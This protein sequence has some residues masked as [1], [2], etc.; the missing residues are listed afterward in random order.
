MTLPMEKED[1]TQSF[2]YKR[3]NPLCVQSPRQST[4]V[5]SCQDSELA[6]RLGGHLLWSAGWSDGL[7]AVRAVKLLFLDITGIMY[8]VISSDL[9]ERMDPCY[10]SGWFSYKLHKML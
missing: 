10:S 5:Q 7:S 4:S 2:R 6:L 8:G 9:T 1:L 3:Q